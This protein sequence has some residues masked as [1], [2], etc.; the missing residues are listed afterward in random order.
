M[1]LPGWLIGASLVVALAVMGIALIRTNRALRVEHKRAQEHADALR[2]LPNI[3]KLEARVAALTVL[4]ESAYNSLLLVDRSLNVIHMNAAARDLFA[5]QGNIHKET[6]MAVTR[7]H[8]ID[9][10]VSQTLTSSRDEQLEQQIV[11]QGRPYRVRA[12]RIETA[13]GKTVALALEDVSELQRLGRARRDMVANIS[14]DL[15]T[16][17]TSIRLLVETLLGGAAAEKARRRS[18]LEKI[19]A[20]T[21]ILLHMAQELLDLAM[22]ES[23]RAEVILIPI[24]LEDINR[25]VIGRLSEQ[26]GRKSV[27]IEDRTPHDLTVLADADQIQRV[28]TNLLHNAIKFTPEGGQISLDAKAIGEWVTV[29]VT[30][31]GP[32]VAHSER[33]RVFE[34]FYRGDRARTSG[35][36]GLGLAIAR[37][38]V[39]AHGGMIRVEEAPGG[40][41]ARLSFTLPLTAKNLS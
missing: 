10:L 6:L 2:E 1:T 9:G 3:S 14:H 41:G 32:G 5:Q 38:I 11:I 21:D 34:R 22:I 29:S 33:E 16:P 25:S 37:H 36:T 20:E 15:R 30:D 18:L 23:G 39:A 12:L 24:K 35:G 13:R 40:F 4:T 17:I 7:Q 26:A 28:L 31:S 8:E 27:T 19:A